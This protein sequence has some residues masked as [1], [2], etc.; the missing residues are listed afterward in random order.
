MSVFKVS[1][2]RRQPRSRQKTRGKILRR[3]LKQFSCSL[4]C[5]W[6]TSTATVKTKLWLRLRMLSVDFKI[7]ATDGRHQKHLTIRFSHPFRPSSTSPFRRLLMFWSW[8]S[9]GHDQSTWDIYLMKKPCIYSILMY[10]EG[11]CN[12]VK[13]STDELVWSEVKVGM[14]RAPFKLDI[15]RRCCRIIFN[16]NKRS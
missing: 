4:K 6:K 16:S 5:F 12:Q 10:S 13:F 8:V 3:N 14:R 2:A 7:P 1:R 11:E 15:G 9:H